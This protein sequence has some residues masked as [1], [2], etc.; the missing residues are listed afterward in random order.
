MIHRMGI[1][2]KAKLASGTFCNFEKPDVV[3]LPNLCYWIV[4]EFWKVNL[5]GNPIG[6]RCREALLVLD[7]TYHAKHFLIAI[8][9]VHRAERVG[10]RCNFVGK[11]RVHNIH[12]CLQHEIYVPAFICI[13][14]LWHDHMGTIAKGTKRGRIVS[15]VLPDRYAKSTQAIIS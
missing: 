7:V 8:G 15:R 1:A 9:A 5:N 13:I 2:A 4:S 6:G 3:A 12:K 14:L 10:Y 11:G